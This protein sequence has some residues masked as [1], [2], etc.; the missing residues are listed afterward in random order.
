MGGAPL[1]Q[2]RKVE[3]PPGQPF[4]TS[5]QEELGGSEDLFF[6]VAVKGELLPALASEDGTPGPPI[7][8]RTEEYRN[9]PAFAL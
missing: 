2:R 9:F 4:L 8:F 5:R 7:V 6:G 3:T 1:S